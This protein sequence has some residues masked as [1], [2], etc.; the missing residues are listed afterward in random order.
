MVFEEIFEEVPDPRDQTAQHE[1][2]DLLF[3]A[4]AAVLCGAKHCTEMELFGEARADLLREFVPLKDGIPSHD[5]F[6][7]VLGALD[8]DAFNAAFARFMAGFG[9]EARAEPGQIAVDGKSLRR[10]YDKGAAHMPPLVVTVYGCQTF[11]SLSQRVAARGGEAEA[12]LEALRLLT[13]QDRIVTADALHC[14]RRMTETIRQAGGHYVIAVKA[15]QSRLAGEVQA[16]LDAAEADPA[17]PV[18]ETEDIAHDRREFRRA[19]VTPFTQSPG[20]NALQDLCAVARVDSWRT[21]NGKACHQRR[22]FVLSK[23]L[24][25]DALLAI[26]RGHWQIENGLHWPLDVHLGE[27]HSRNRKLNGPANIALLR[28]LAL[29]VLRRQPDKRPLSHKQLMARWNEHALLNLLTYVR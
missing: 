15:N 28:R 11:L 7:R 19:L 10:A 26:V 4:F 2:T 25:P 17:T 12:A 18:A 5:T 14:H 21:H 8:P 6:S 22:Q 29:N 1:L 3:V 20:K 9:A 24:S 27:D 16:A 13:L 23:P